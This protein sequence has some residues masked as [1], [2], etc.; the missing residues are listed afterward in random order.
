MTMRR[1][2]DCCRFEK[3]KYAIYKRCC[4]PKLYKYAERG[5][6]DL[7]PQRCKSSPKEAS[8]V[9]KFPPSDTA[10][11][12]LIRV[13]SGMMDGVGSTI[14]QQQQFKQVQLE[15]VS[16][17]LGANPSAAYMPDA[18]GRTPLHLA[19][20][21][22]QWNRQAVARLA[23]V[24]CEAPVGS[25]PLTHQDM[26]GRTPLHYLVGRNQHI[27][28]DLLEQM[29]LVRPSLLEMR[30]LVSE[31]PL[32]ICLERKHEIENVEEVLQVLKTPTIPQQEEPDKAVLAKHA[33]SSSS[34]TTSTVATSYR[35][36]TLS[37]R[38]PVNLTRA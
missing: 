33:G 21:D 18:F 36:E 1:N 28:I 37:R 27:P 9:H 17:L 35:S 2:D 30:D 34:L 15:A 20:M 16:A 22:I 4:E 10:L 7:I 6:W 26:E 8:F 11:H 19:C 29:I 14:Q 13:S 24:G 3:L 31:T 32:D 38:N 25:C 12:R 23:E 5:D